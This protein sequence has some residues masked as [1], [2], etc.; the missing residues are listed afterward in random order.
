VTDDP[1]SE[2][3]LVRCALDGPVAR[4]TLASP[5]NRN[6]LSRR[7]LEDLHRALDTAL[8]PS[9]RVV[10]LDHV[11]PAFCAGADLKERSRG[12]ADSSP[13]VDALRRIETATQPV[14]AAVKGPVRAGGIGLMA[15]C[16]LVVIEESVDLAFTE[17]RLGL[18][19]AI[20]SVPVLRRAPASR[21]AAAF[22]T[23]ETFGARDARD[24]GLVTHVAAGAAAVD[25]EVERLVAG[26]LLGAPGAVAATK[27]I[28]HEVP[29]A[30]GV[31]DAYTAMQRLSEDLFEAA[32][33]REGM[34][35]FLEKRR[36]GWQ[37]P[38]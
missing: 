11:P 9:V 31:D 28:L 37:P 21:L 23:G 32:E 19:A 14:I 33:G 12:P 16:D 13:L 25:A 26:V 29:G 15:A 3:P 5:R 35:A 27:R 36:P 24:I 6:A 1:L 17:V 30:A 18:A 34:Q 8:A 38:A 10:V 20:I 2:T 4:I 7:L 22:L